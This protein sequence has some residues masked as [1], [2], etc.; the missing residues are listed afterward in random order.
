MQSA[1]GHGTD[2]CKT[3][4]VA[5]NSDNNLYLYRHTILRTPHVILFHLFNPKDLI[6][7][8]FV[9]SLPNTLKHI[10]SDML[11]FGFILKHV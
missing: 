4:W 11:H 2:I 8:L 6:N 10:A 7:R 9:K 1:Y 3:F 5:D